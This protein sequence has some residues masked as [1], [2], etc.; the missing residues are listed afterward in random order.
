[1]YSFIIAILK[2]R[3]KQISLDRFILQRPASEREESVP[4]MARVSDGEEE[5]D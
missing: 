4:I 3:K 2:G 1:M 5:G